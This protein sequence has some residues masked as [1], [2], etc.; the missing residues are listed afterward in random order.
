MGKQ[1][2]L[3]DGHEADEIPVGLF[4]PENFQEL[5][6]S[7]INSSEILRKHLDHSS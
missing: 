6:E 4:T 5:L 3:L 7:Q 2:I 1:N